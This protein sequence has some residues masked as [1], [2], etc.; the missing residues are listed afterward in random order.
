VESII[1]DKRRNTG[2]IGHGLEE[3]FVAKMAKGVDISVMTLTPMETSVTSV[4][5]KEVEVNLGRSAWNAWKEH[6]GAN[7]L[8]IT[9]FGDSYITIGT[10]WTQSI[11]VANASPVYTTTDYPPSVLD[12]CAIHLPGLDGVAFIK[13]LNMTKALYWWIICTIPSME[14][15]RDWA[16]QILGE[17]WSALLVEGRNRMSWCTLSQSTDGSIWLEYKGRK[18]LLA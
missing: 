12:D 6:Y 5:F 8:E 14:N 15:R 7:L 10:V 11:A 18:C 13:K 3:N 4:T 16:Q 9:P 1:H 2:S 17:E